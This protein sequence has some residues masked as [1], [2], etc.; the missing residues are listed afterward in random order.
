MVVKPVIPGTYEL[1][2]PSTIA[3]TVE[4][5]YERAINYP[6]PRE[7]SSFIFHNGLVKPL[8][9]NFQP[10]PDLTPVLAIGSNAS[11][12]QLRRKFQYPVT[13]PVLQVTVHNA[14]V[15]Y[16]A[17]L[18]PYGSVAASII[19]SPSTQVS[20][21]VT[22]LD[23]RT[24]KRMNETEYGYALCKVDTTKA[25]IVWHDDVHITD[26]VLCYVV[27]E[28]ALKLDRQPIAIKAIPARNR[29]FP[30]LSQTHVL[31]RVASIVDYRPTSL[32]QF[33]LDIVGDT[34]R[35][36]DAMRRL[37]RRTGV[38]RCFKVIQVLGDPYASPKLI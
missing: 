37:D 15:V 16:G 7:S 30:E 8:P 13:I 36:C 9:P 2:A 1:S 4:Q 28:G 17:R 38:D 25:P 29:R 20:S 27:A 12:Q 19:A 33:I 10:S 11:P 18:A 6:Y 24:L 26:D 34:E 5:I 23:Q 22:F 35:R 31:Q 14:D 3:P 21:F 32:T